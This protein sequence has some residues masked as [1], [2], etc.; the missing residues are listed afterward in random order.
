MPEGRGFPGLDKS[1]LGLM[2]ASVEIFHGLVFVNLD[3]EA[4]PLAPTLA[5]LEREARAVRHRA[6]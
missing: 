1:Q 6:A 2:P 4:A 3:P 5:G